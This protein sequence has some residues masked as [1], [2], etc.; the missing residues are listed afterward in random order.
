VASETGRPHP[1]PPLAAA[2]VAIGPTNAA[3]TNVTTT[4]PN[5]RRI[6]STSSIGYQVDL[7][8]GRHVPLDGEEPLRPPR[9]PWE[10][11]SRAA[12]RSD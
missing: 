12:A 11:R 4:H 7:C 8:R 9:G 3:A 6:A 10:G 2:D 5:A 1:P